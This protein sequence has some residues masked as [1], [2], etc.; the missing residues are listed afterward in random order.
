MS[1][2]RDSFDPVIFETQNKT[3]KQSDRQRKQIFIKRNEIVAC[4]RANQY[5]C[6]VKFPKGVSQPYLSEIFISAEQ[7]MIFTK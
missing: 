3:Q 1:L 6:A 2:I 4:N 5:I 7:S